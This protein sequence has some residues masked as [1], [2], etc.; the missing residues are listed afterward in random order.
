MSKIIG[1]PLFSEDEIK[2]IYK[3]FEKK[4]MPFK[5]FKKQIDELTNPVSMQ[6]DL[7]LLMEQRKKHGHS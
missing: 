4:D 7:K 2:K 6:A 1:S 3:G 5:E